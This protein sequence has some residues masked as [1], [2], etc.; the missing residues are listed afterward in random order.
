MASERVAL[1]YKARPAFAPF[2][3]RKQRFGCIVAHRRAGKTVASIM[4]L[5]DHALRCTKQDGRFAYVAPY[6]AQAKDV[7]WAYVKRYTG[8]IPGAAINESE[9]RV[10]LPNGARI[11]LYG[12]DNYDRMR[13]IYLDG[14]VLDEYADQPPQAWREVIRPAL[15]D[16]QGWAVFIGT[17]KGRNAFHEV[18]QTAT[19][20]ED[21][22]SLKL[23]AS[24]TGIVDQ[25]ELDA[26]RAQMSANE[27]N[28]EMECDFD[29]A[30]E[31]AY[32]A[33]LIA[34]ART[35]GRVGDVTPDPNMTMRVYCDLG[36]AGAKADAFSMWAVQ[37]VGMQIR[38]LNYYE[39]QGQPAAEHLAWLREKGL[40][41]AEIFLPH[42]GLTESGP[43]PGSWER[44]FREAGFSVT[45]LRGEGSGN[46]GAKAVRIE[47]VRRRLS[48]CWFD[49]KNTRAGIDALISYHEKR[50]EKRGVGLGPAHDWCLAVGTQ[51]L[52]PHGWR[53]IEDF[54]VHDE[55]L[56]PC[57]AR[58]ILRSGIVRETREWAV[59]RGVRCTPEH[60]FFTSRGL[61]EA[62][63]LSPKDELW[64][65]ESLGLRIL[66]FLSATLSFGFK[67]AITLATQEGRATDGGRFSYTG[68]FTRLCMV[69][70][71][72][73]MKSIILMITRSITA[74]T[75]LPQFL[76]SSIAANINQS[77]GSPAFAGFV[78]K[79]LVATRDLGQD[80]ARSVG[81]GT[82]RELSANAEPAYNLTVE[83]DE[84]YYVRGSDN[85]AYLV[86]NSSHGADAFGLMAVA[87]EIPVKAHK[88]DLSNLTRG[89]V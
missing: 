53:L 11:R 2:H 44:T 75:I 89:R 60:R 35:D 41:K 80:A 66:A 30:I 69:K 71:R 16:R 20:N 1:G 19:D 5:I 79:S 62:G 8:Q 14:V 18:Y 57:G 7:V 54:S 88:L 46:S 74:R 63:E 12:A 77:L 51:V 42:D 23:K 22:F 73:V 82:M 34:D 38:V 56:T 37:F 25:A 17:P 40:T 55:V 33:S 39:S 67:A 52:T 47:A 81:D 87:Y 27:Y 29:A 68:W 10:D 43:N 65:R 84:C 13:G 61:V 76:V 26:M 21:W 36:G 49:E 15:A 28:R 32:Y 72:L 4:D 9:L 59:V 24:E 85:Q 48:S 78:G 70:Y 64:T 86:S 50:D 3:R 45:T 83:I 6:Y 31:G 58:R